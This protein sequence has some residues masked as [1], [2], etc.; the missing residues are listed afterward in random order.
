MF[1][2]REIG[3]FGAGLDPDFQVT[4]LAVR[5]QNVGKLYS[6]T[7]KRYTW[8]FDVCPL[9]SKPEAA[10]QDY[11]HMQVTFTDSTMSAKRSLVVNAT[12][13]LDQDIM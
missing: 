4:K 5:V 13:V 9:G 7:K 12:T 6:A 1:R 8:T 10:I 11:Q 3:E 2:G